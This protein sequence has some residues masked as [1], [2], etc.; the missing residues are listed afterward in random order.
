M[1]AQRSWPMPISCSAE[2][3][4]SGGCLVPQCSRP[5][6]MQHDLP[7]KKSNEN[8]PLEPLRVT[9]SVC[10]C[11][12]ANAS[13]FL[14]L[15]PPVG[16]QTLLTAHSY[17]SL[18]P[19]STS[20]GIRKEPKVFLDYIFGA[21]RYQRKLVKVVFERT[22]V[23]LVRGLWRPEWNRRKEKASDWSLALCLCGMGWEGRPVLH[24]AREQQLV[25]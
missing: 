12:S 21:W 20:T 7:P 8:F 13:S 1:P 23:E 15:G 11:L 6:T 5:F 14:K 19:N 16:H 25:T 9:P 2:V 4:G 24:Q 18:L 3:P 22:L 17:A 10:A